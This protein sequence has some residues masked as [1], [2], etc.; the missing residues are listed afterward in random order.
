[1]TLERQLLGDLY[2]LLRRMEA[3]P[4]HDFPQSGTGVRVH[5]HP[6]PSRVVPAPTPEKRCT[7]AD[8]AAR[9]EEYVRLMRRIK[10]LLENAPS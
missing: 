10:K 3:C 5:H 4:A 7:G 6:D 9:E 1:M 2:A 8:L